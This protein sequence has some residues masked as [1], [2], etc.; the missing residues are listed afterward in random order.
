MDAPT[1]NDIISED[2]LDNAANDD[3]N[4]SNENDGGGTTTRDILNNENSI[5]ASDADEECKIEHIDD[6]NNGPNL[7]PA[8]IEDINNEIDKNQKR[9]DSINTITPPIP[10]NYA[11]F[12]KDIDE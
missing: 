6:D 9:I 3:D 11:E 8:V 7:P 10:F 1:P 4:N 2:C 12:E 5:L